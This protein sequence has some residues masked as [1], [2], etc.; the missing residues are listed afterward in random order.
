MSI[1]DKAK[2]LLPKLKVYIQN[3]NNLK[4]E[5]EKHEQ[6]VSYK[7]TEQD[8]VFFRRILG[9]KFDH[10]KNEIS[11]A[12]DIFQRRALTGDNGENLRLELKKIN[13]LQNKLL[14]AL[15]ILTELHPDILNEI[16]C[17]LSEQRFNF[18]SYQSN[19]AKHIKGIFIGP[20]NYSSL[21]NLTKELYSLVSVCSYWESFTK[22]SNFKPGPNEKH[23]EQLLLLF[24]HGLFNTNQIPIKDHNES[25]FSRTYL[26]VLRICD[27]KISNPRAIIRR[28]LKKFKLEFS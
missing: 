17:G 14:D 10:V 6:Y 15:Q 1:Y 19:P 16:S 13:K 22:Y 9:N 18:Q 20:K 7:L 23:P 2:K 4:V 27:H 21:P 3:F 8:S 26:Q 25:I 28:T 11:L 12:I 24:L 5:N